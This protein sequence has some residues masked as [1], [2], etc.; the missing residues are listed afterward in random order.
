MLLYD[1]ATNPQVGAYVVNRDI[2]TQS[3]TFAASYSDNKSIEEFEI[4]T[5]EDPPAELL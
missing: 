3:A 5:W 2:T 1:I 4:S